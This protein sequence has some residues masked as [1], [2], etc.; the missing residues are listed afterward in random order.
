MWFFC[1]FQSHKNSCKNLWLLAIWSCLSFFDS[2]RKS[3]KIIDLKILLSKMLIIS[4]QTTILFTIFLFPWILNDFQALHWLI[5]LWS[6]FIVLLL[7]LLR[8]REDIGACMKGI[9]IK[10]WRRVANAAISEDAWICSCLC[11]GLQRLSSINCWTKP[12]FQF[13]RLIRR[14]FEQVWIG[15]QMSTANSTLGTKCLASDCWVRFTSSWETWAVC[16]TPMRE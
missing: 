4:F 8:K 14:E 11:S 10:C 1:N 3:N 5:K 16:Q 12:S 13:A 2:S 15:L 9:I 7:R 6:L